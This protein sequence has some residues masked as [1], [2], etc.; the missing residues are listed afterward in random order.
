MPRQFFSFSDVTLPTKIAAWSVFIWIVVILKLA[1]ARYNL[2]AYEALDLSIYAQVMWNTVHGNWFVYT[3]NNYSYL[4]DH[5]EWIL[6]LIAPLFAI[7]QHPLMLVGIQTFVLASSAYPLFRIVTEHAFKE[8]PY[9]GWIG[10]AAILLVLLHPAIQSMA[11]YEFHALTFVV[12]AAFFFWWAVLEQRIKSMWAFAILAL[13]VREDVGLMMCG[14]GVLIALRFRGRMRIHGI[15]LA[16]VASVW[17]LLMIVLGGYFF[18]SGSEKFLVFYPQLGSSMSEVFTSILYHPLQ[19]FAPLWQYDHLWVILLLCTS[20][21]ALCVL[22][23]MLL[24]P[25]IAPLML[26][27]L[28]P[29]P[30]LPSLLGTHY[31]AMLVPWFVLASCYGLRRVYAVY[32]ARTRVVVSTIAAVCISVHMVLLSGIIYTIADISFAQASTDAY[33]VSHVLSDIG[34]ADSVLVSH[35]FAPYL[36]TRAQLYPALQ[37]FRGKEHYAETP[38]AIPGPVDWVVLRPRDMVEMTLNFETEDQSGIS[39]WSA[40]ARVIAEHNLHR[41]ASTPDVMVWGKAES[42]LVQGNDD[43]EHVQTFSDVAVE[44]VALRSCVPQLQPALE[45][46]EPSY[47]VSCTFVRTHTTSFDGDVHILLSWYGLKG[48]STSQWVNVVTQ[49]LLPSHAWTVGQEYVVTFPV[50]SIIASRATLSLVG[51]SAQPEKIFFGRTELDLSR[52]PHVAA[53]VTSLLDY[54][55][56][57]K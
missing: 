54:V 30:M 25:A 44:G 48:Q 46:T 28:I 35:G 45:S 12:P 7:W 47:M 42:M 5:R 55:V 20:V 38:Y 33:R 9:R 4:A 23:P 39:G 10:L 31:S 37:V 18:P 53:D 22:E 56:S 27:L 24:F 19:S 8:N 11:L 32:S 29:K 15:A 13:L 3:F 26:F 6:L 16:G 49:D 14:A 1:T 21:G 36:A 40:F 52:F 17:T 51:V 34:D 57:E 2:F 50:R 43:T 41:V